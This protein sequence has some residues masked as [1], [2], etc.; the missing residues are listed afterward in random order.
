[1]ALTDPGY[2]RRARCP[3]QK[4]RGA[5]LFFDITPTNLGT[6]EMKNLQE[7]LSESKVYILVTTSTT[8]AHPLM[9]SGTKRPLLTKLF[10]FNA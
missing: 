5:K 10:G 9:D 8:P 6:T 7:N 4:E 2:L 1:M 3:T